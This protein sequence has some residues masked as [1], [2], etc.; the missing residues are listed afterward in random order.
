[1]AAQR[2]ADR[3]AAAAERAADRAAQAVAEHQR[4]VR[5][6]LLV[7]ASAYLRASAAMIHLLAQLDDLLYQERSYEAHLQIKDLLLTVEGARSALVLLVDEPIRTRLFRF[8]EVCLMYIEGFSEGR[9]RS[10]DRAANEQ[11]QKL[12]RLNNDIT[13]L[14]ARALRTTDLPPSSGRGS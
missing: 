13:N 4:F 8:D 5:E 12:G 11:F 2:Q 7:A 14:T 1:M 3:V 10:N 9:V 6:E